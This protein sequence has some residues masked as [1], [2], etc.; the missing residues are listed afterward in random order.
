[1]HVEAVEASRVE[2]L[3]A[4]AQRPASPEVRL[5]AEHPRAHPGVR[6]A[7]GDEGFD[8]R[9][10]SGVL[11]GGE[12]QKLRWGTRCLDARVRQQPLV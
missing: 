10:K 4:V 8:E 5:P 3:G 12:D 9:F 6:G 11:R 2:L 7:C 1:M